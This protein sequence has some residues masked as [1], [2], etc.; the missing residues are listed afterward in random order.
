[1]CLSNSSCIH[2]FL[3]KKINSTFKLIFKTVTLV[4]AWISSATENS[5][6]AICNISGGQLL[7][8]IEQLLLDFTFVIS[9]HLSY[10]SADRLTGWLQQQQCLHPDLTP[11]ENMSNSAILTFCRHLFIIEQSS[12][13]TIW[14]GYNAYNLWHYS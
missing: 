5:T 11:F 13:L 3:L 14:T 8:N 12:K 6:I 2:L 7:W 1:M 10:S 4:P 9:A